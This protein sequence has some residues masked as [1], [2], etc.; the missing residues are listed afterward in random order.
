MSLNSTYVNTDMISL[1]KLLSDFFPIDWDELRCLSYNLSPVNNAFCIV[2]KEQGLQ[3]SSIAGWNCAQLAG[4]WGLQLKLKPTKTPTVRGK[5]KRYE[6]LED[7]E[8]L[9]PHP[10]ICSFAVDQFT[11][12]WS[13]SSK[14]LD[15][16][17]LKNIRTSVLKTHSHITHTFLG[18][19]PHLLLC[20]S[21]IRK[22]NIEQIFGHFFLYLSWPSQ[23]PS[24]SV[25]ILP[26][27][28]LFPFSPP[29]VDW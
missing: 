29:F 28:P 14:G 12:F 26:F 22:W 15:T 23:F 20:D 10:W 19:L 3:S 17:F 4:S 21:L 8:S 2:H 27:F 5:K 7:G 1:R 24:I 13:P 16:N 18:C 6:V 11:L 9:Q 25:F